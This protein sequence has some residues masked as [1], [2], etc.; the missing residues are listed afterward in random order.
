MQTARWMIEPS[1]SPVPI[2]ACLPHGGAEYPPDLAADLAM[3]PDE[4][5]P[6][7]LTRELYDFLPELGITTIT[8]NYS[9]F[10][11]DVNRDPGGDQH[12]AFRDSVV[13]AHLNSGRQLYRRELTQDQISYRIR[14]AHEPFHR[15]LDQAVD[16]LLSRHDRILLLDLHSFGIDLAGDI[17]VGDRHGTTADPATT[18]RIQ[19]ALISGTGLDVRLNQRYIGGWTVKRFAA[20]DRVDAVAIEV[21][22]RCYLDLR[23]RAHPAKLPLRDFDQTRQRLRRALEHIVREP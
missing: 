17:I 2:I 7:L 6:D 20:H 13:A 14:L 18:Q 16:Q 5:R 9:R 3:S 21:N 10:V 15:A 4:L 8:T 19:E 23:H 1:A 22:Q 11:A 12:G